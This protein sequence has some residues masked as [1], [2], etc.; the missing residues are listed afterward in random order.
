[1]PLATEVTIA[2]P[3]GVLTLD[4]P[5]RPAAFL[6]G[7]I[8]ITPF[9]SILYQATNDR[10][11]RR[12]FL[13]YSN[14]RPEDAAFLEQLEGLEKAN[15]NYTFIGSMTQM[16]KSTRPWHGETRYIDKKMLE[17]FLGDLKPPLYYLAGPA[18]MVSAMRKMLADA[19]AGDEQV[20]FEAF[21]GY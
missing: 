11:S 18:A 17:N 19:G 4:G 8:G 5:D 9:R 21:S 7:G 10:L 6:T 20:R 2:G 16:E 3:Y 13:F 12:L 14:R 1:M 15:P